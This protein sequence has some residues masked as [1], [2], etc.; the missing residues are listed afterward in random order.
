MFIGA[1][2]ILWG[3]HLTCG[4]QQQKPAQYVNYHVGRE[5]DNFIVS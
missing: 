2:D 5:K 1:G 4:I 3:F